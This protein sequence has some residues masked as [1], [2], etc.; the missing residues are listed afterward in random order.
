MELTHEVCINDV[1]IFIRMLPQCSPIAICCVHLYHIK[2]FI[3]L[4]NALLSNYGILCT[5]LSS[6]VFLICNCEVL[7]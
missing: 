4:F 2:F 6:L 1:I 5:L 7:C 3:I